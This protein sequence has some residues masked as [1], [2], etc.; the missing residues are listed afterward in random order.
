MP[1]KLC[2]F[3]AMAFGQKDTDAIFRALRETLGLL[4]I[5]VQRVD[6]IEHNDNI[7]TRIIIQVRV[8]SNRVGCAA[9]SAPN[10]LS[11][12]CIPTVP[13]RWFNFSNDRPDEIDEDVLVLSLGSGGMKRL[14]KQLPSARPGSAK[15][16]FQVSDHEKSY[17]GPRQVSDAGVHAERS[18]AAIRPTAR[19]SERGVC[20]DRL[21]RCQ[22]VRSRVTID[23]VTISCERAAE[24]DVQRSSLWHRMHSHAYG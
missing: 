20:H 21:E 3:V 10:I 9:E 17:R 16:V 13:W 4:G 23:V 22:G 8:L 12:A 7:D 5:N 19:G 24:A 18:R 15:H 14:Q 11:V 6:R 1:A 2:C